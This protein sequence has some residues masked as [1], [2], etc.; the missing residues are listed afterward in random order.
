MANKENAIVRLSPDQIKNISLNSSSPIEAL[1]RINPEIAALAYADKKN[2][3]SPKMIPAIVKFRE[4][5]SNEKIAIVNALVIKYGMDKFSEVAK[6]RVDG[7]VDMNRTSEEHATR[8]TGLREDGLTKR[9]N[10]HENG[11]TERTSI[12]QLQQTERELAKMDAY[13]DMH[14]IEYEARVKMMEMQTQGQIKISENQLRATYAQAEAH[15]D[16]IISTERIRADAK[17]GIAKSKLEARL[18]EAG[19]KFATKIREAELLTQREAHSNR[20]RVAETYLRLQTQLYLENLQKSTALEIRKAELSSK[21]YAAKQQTTRE[22][23]D[24]LKEAVKQGRKNARLLIEDSDGTT[25]LD[26]SSED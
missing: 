3:L 4:Y 26:F 11:L 13:K 7:Q 2:I 6:Y 23:I 18:K 22:G 17:K 15:R 20:S 1:Y 5:Q 24:L 21:N 9:L 25:F 12:E 19:I 16:A 10:L 14:R 8:R